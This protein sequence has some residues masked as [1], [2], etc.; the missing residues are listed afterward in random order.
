MISSDPLA[1]FAASLRLSPRR[2]FER[3]FLGFA[4]YS[5]EPSFSPHN[6]I[7]FVDDIPEVVFA[8]LF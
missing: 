3:V 8:L 4:L 7:R 6:A 2:Y 1:S 5:A